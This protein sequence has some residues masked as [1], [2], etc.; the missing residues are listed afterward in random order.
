MTGRT[1][2]VPRDKRGILLVV[3]AALSAGCSNGQTTEPA[4]SN[5]TGPIDRLQVFARDWPDEYVEID[6]KREAN[7]STL[8]MISPPHGGQPSV[9]LESIGPATNDPPQIVELLNR[10]DVWAMADSNAAGAACNTSKGYWDCNATSNDYSLVMQ[11]IRGGVSRSQRY[12]NLHSQSANAN[13]RA[14]A[15]FMI[16]WKH[17][18]ES[19]N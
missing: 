2:L 3:L 16:A 11:V 12:T 14:L 9:L 7:G 19:R 5:V 4:P 6:F 15:D 1:H 17:E 8:V 10:F 13:A 18:V